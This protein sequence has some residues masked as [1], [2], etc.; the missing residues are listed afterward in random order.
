MEIKYYTTVREEAA[1]IDAIESSGGAIARYLAWQSGA[2][3]R[4][5]NPDQL[6][7]FVLSPDWADGLTGAVRLDVVQP[8]FT[9]LQPEQG[10]SLAVHPKLRMR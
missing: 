6:R 7:R 2:L 3:G 5:I 10:R 9:Q 8:V 1:A 4:D